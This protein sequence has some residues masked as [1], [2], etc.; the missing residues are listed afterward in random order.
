MNKQQLIQKDYSILN[1]GNKLVLPMDQ[2]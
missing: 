2:L 1:T